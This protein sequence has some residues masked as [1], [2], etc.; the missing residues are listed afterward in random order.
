M[1]INP[2]KTYRILLID[3]DE[4]DRKIFKRSLNNSSLKHYLFEAINATDALSSIRSNSFDCIFLDYRIPGS[5]GLELLIN[6]KK[7]D[8]ITGVAVMTSHGDET[9]AIEMLKAGALDYMNKSDIDSDEIE[10]IVHTSVKMRQIENERAHAEQQS[11]QHVYQLE[12]ILESTNSSVLSVDRDLRLTGFNK[13]YKETIRK[14]YGMDVKIGDQLQDMV[15]GDADPDTEKEMLSRAFNGEQF[16][17]EEHYGLDEA[18]RYFF[19]ISYNPVRNE[20]NEVTGVA[21]FAQDVTEKKRVEQALTKA[22]NEALKAAQVKTDFLSNMSHEIRT[23]MNAIIGITDL[24]LDRITDATHRDFLNS[25]KYSADNLLVIINDILDF[26]KIEAGKIVIESIPFD[27][28]ENLEEISKAFNYQAKEKHIDLIVNIGPDVPRMIMGDPYRLNQILFNLVGNAI[29]F[30][31]EGSVSIEVKVK[32]KLSDRYLIYFGVTDT[33]I[34]ISDDKITT[35]FESFTQA[36]TDTA[37]KFGGTGLG[38]AITKNLVELQNGY[39]GLTSTLKKG[40]TFYFEIPYAESKSAQ[41]TSLPGNEAGQAINSLKGYKV[42]LVEDNTMNQLVAQQILLKWSADV[43]IAET[44]VEALKY[45][46]SEK[47]DI[48][49]MDLQMPEMSGYEATR[50]IRGDNKLVL[51]PAVPIIALTADAFEETRVKVLKSGMNDFVTKPFKQ[52]ELYNKIIKYLT[53]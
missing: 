12:A 10:R 16:V 8:P 35:I 1:Q 17:R 29:K 30:T 43:S 2:D 19:E 23:P 37:R 5:D 21:I 31:I 50:Q 48:V 42:L 40:S 51:N 33:G 39:L 38:L 7:A 49:L 4:L 9:I 22:R 36:Y 26:S 18:N 46:T 32:Q 20:N 27:L 34:G 41:P 53:V 45:L 15:F 52:E 6:I 47:F 13:A 14:I 24:L 25:I 3:D 44:G 28:R 11:K